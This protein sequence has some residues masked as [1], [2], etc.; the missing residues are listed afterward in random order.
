MMIDVL[1]LMGMHTISILLVAAL[2]AAILIVILL[3]K[4]RRKTEREEAKLRT[5]VGT[6][7]C[8]IQSLSEDICRLRDAVHSMQSDL[9]ALV[10][11]SSEINLETKSC[12]RELMDIATKLESNL[13]ELNKWVCELSRWT[14]YLR[15]YTHDLY[16]VLANLSESIH[17]L[18]HS[19]GG[20]NTHESM[21]RFDVLSLILLSSDLTERLRYG[22]VDRELEALK[23][24]LPFTTT[25]LKDVGAIYMVRNSGEVVVISE[26]EIG[27]E[28]AK[29][30]GK[31]ANVKVLN[32]VSAQLQRF[33]Q[34]LTCHRG[35]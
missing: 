27:S 3:S 16:N 4:L 28:R 35:S 24:L 31:L 15:D 8:S 1:S 12:L 20:E 30:L 2:P 14:S 19:I 17:G 13:S 29:V 7:E 33:V 26:L 25:L 21:P 5:Y 34:E 32:E 11:G 10:K 9:Q 23:M 6:I 18:K 22:N